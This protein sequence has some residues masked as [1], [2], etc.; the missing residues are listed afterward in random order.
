[1]MLMR[2]RELPSAEEFIIGINEETADKETQK[3][4]APRGDE[5]ITISLSLYLS[6]YL[7]GQRAFLLLREL[8]RKR[9]AT[10]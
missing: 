7:F 5:F 8:Y 4:E 2:I 9:E 10:K 1:M 3:E 6:V